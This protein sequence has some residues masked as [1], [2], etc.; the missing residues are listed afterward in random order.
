MSCVVIPARLVGNIRGGEGIIEI[1]MNSISVIP[2]CFTRPLLLAPPYFMSHNPSHITAIPATTH[3][4]LLPPTFTSNLHRPPTPPSSHLHLPPS[5]PPPSHL[6]LHPSTSTFPQIHLPS[7]SHPTSHL[8]LP[9]LTSSQPLLSL[10]P[11]PLPPLP[12]STLPAPLQTS[13]QRR[14]GS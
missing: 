10:L 6:Y 7:N 12:P 4:Y 3:L 2:G 11:P 13:L 1:S 14:R 5:P 8:Y 9:A